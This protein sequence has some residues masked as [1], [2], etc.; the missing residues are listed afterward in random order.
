MRL[1]VAK[2]ALIVLPLVAFSTQGFAAQDVVVVA[3][4]QVSNHMM[5][6]KKE[7]HQKLYKECCQV[8]SVAGS[9]DESLPSQFSIKEL[10]KRYEE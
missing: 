10:R 6:V 1:F 3:K 9:D 2:A 4:Q 8:T 7:S 5:K